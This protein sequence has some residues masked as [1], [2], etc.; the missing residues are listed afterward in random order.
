MFN[1]HTVREYFEDSGRLN[2][3]RVNAFS[4]EAIKQIVSFN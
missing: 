3:V 4:S 1:S 2:F